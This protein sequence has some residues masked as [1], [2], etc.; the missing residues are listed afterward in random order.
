M[1]FAATTGSFYPD[2]IAYPDGAIPADAIEVS[3]ADFQAAMAR[4]D[5]ATLTVKNGALA[6]VAQSTSDALAAA[7]TARSALMDAACASEIISGFV[8]SA[9]GASY[10]YPSQQTDQINLAANVLSSILPNLAADWTTLQLCAD[11][12]GAWSYRAHT[13]EQI[14]QVG[15][16]AK[17]AVMALLTKKGGLQAEIASATTVA[18]VNAVAW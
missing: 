2:D 15:T 12:G 17:A 8:S 10:T 14:Q 9:L 13:A 5:G 7:K 16:D 3:D 11:A 1:K 6:I 18:A 4:A